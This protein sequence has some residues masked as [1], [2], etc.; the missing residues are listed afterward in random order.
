MVLLIF[1]ERELIEGTTVIV[2]HR[3]TYEIDGADRGKIFY[4]DG[5]IVL[6]CGAAFDEPLGCLCL[7]NGKE[8]Y[9]YD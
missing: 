8:Y 6:D 1:L 2:G 7:D 3:P 5:S 9:I 4:G